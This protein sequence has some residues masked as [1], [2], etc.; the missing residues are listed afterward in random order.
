M[1]HFFALL[2]G[3]PGAYGVAFPDCPGCTAM[4]ADENEAY[5][6][7][8]AALDEWMRDAQAAGGRPAA[9]GIEALRRD[10]D[11]NAAVAEGAIFLRI[12]YVNEFRPAGE[13]QHFARSRLVGRDRCG[14]SK[15]RFELDRLFSPA[16]RGK[17]SPPPVEALRS[18]HMLVACSARK[19]RSDFI[20]YPRSDRIWAISPAVDG[21]RALRSALAS[22]TI[23]ARREASSLP[24]STPHW[25]NGLMSQTAASTNT[26]CS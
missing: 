1:Q 21:S 16:R 5:A 26:L 14:G 24:S 11:V 12:P 17:K 7:A 19:P 15:Q 3:G 22:A 8:I 2:D 4:G 25:S 9:R 18:F 13:G 23:G 10:P 6:N 20:R